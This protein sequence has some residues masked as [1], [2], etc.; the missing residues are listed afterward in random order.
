MAIC[1]NAAIP[2]GERAQHLL[3]LLDTYAWSFKVRS[4]KPDPTIYQ[5]FLH[6]LDHQPNEVFFI[7]DIQLA[8]VNGPQILGIPA[9]LLDRNNNENL[10]NVFKH[11][12]KIKYK[13]LL[14]LIL[15]IPNMVLNS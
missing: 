3:P 14:K 5:Y 11:F 10:F 12:L 2:Y 7:G 6:Q 8:N 13:S 4:N 15:K 1:S 9:R